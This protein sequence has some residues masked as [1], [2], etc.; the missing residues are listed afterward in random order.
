LEAHFL[1]K[2]KSFE[3][4]PV[5][6]LARKFTSEIYRLTNSFSKGEMYGMTSQIRRAAVSIGSNIAEGF[7]RRTDKELTNYLSMARG[8]CAEIQ[9]DLYIALDLKYISEI[10]FKK[11]YQDTKKIAQQLNGLMNYLRNV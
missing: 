1:A 9:N 5:W 8:S 7:D 3:E 11:Y 2:I 6:Q 4:L 10:E